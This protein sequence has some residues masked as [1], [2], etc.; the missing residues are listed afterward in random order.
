MVQPSLFNQVAVVTGASRGIGRETALLLAQKGAAVVAAAQS[1]REIEDVADQIRQAGGRAAQVPTDVSQ[2]EQAQH[3]AHETQRLFGATDI[4]V[5]NAG[6]LAPFGMTWETSPEDWARNVDINLIGGFYTV[7]AFLPAMVERRHG[8]IILVSSGAALHPFLGAGAYASSK[9]ELN[10]FGRNLS[11]ELAEQSIPL[12]V[13]ILQPGVVNT[14]MQASIRST[15]QQEFPAVERFRVFYESGLL[16]SPRE[17]AELIFWLTT[18]A[19]ADLDGQVVS[20]DDPEIRRRVFEDL[21]LQL[22]GR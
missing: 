15:T 19:A 11:A 16:R 7:R 3:L 5:V 17:P 1:S 10:H 14:P 13:Y 2:W 8:I 12:R 6:V 4:L 22:K 18:P 9:A 21:G 20:I